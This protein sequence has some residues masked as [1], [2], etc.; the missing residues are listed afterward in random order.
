[1]EKVETKIIQVENRKHYF[2]CDECNKYLGVSEEYDDGYYERYGDFELKFYV[3]G[4]YRVNKC[5]CASCREDFVNNLKE[6]LFSI[7]FKF[8]W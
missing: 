2:Y 3:D 8:E 5:L 7:G 4:W 6:S 1:M